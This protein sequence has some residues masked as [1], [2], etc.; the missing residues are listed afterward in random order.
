MSDARTTFQKDLEFIVVS[1]VKYGNLEM[2]DADYILNVAP[3][4]EQVEAYN[5]L[6]KRSAENEG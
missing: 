6:M 3:Y 2:I 1:T 4:R 5:A